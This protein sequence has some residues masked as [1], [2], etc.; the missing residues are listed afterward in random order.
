MSWAWWPSYNDGW[1][2]LHDLTACDA[3]GANG[4]GNAGFYCNQKVDALLK[5]AESAPDDATYNKAMAELQQILTQDDPPAIYYAQ[6]QTTLMA[7]KDIQ[8]IVIN[9][10]NVGTYYF[11]Q[12][13]RA[14]A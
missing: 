14:G 9:P 5:Q 11:Y 8:G 12:M 2:H 6:I 13:S 4:G 3:R 7:Q 1:S 10:I